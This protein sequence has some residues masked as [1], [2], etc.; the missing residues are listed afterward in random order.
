M[1][2]PASIAKFAAPPRDIIDCEVFCTG[3]PLGLSLFVTG[4]LLLHPPM[5]IAETI[6]SV[7]NT[8]FV[9]ILFNFIGE[10]IFTL[11]S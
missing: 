2:E 5:I 1:A 9:F 8:I 10:F 6:A 3:M 4:S 11:Q 7:V